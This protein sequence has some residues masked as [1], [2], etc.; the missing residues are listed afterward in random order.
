MQPRVTLAIARRNLR[1]V[2][3]DPSPIIIYLLIPLLSMVVMK[4]TQKEILVGEGFPDANGAEQVVPGFMVM[5][6][7]LWM[8]SIGRT[9]FVEHGWGTWERLRASSATTADIVM[10]KLAPGFLLMAGQIVISVGLGVVLLDLNSKGP[11]LA[12]VIVAIPLIT[13]VLAMTAAFVGLV[14][15][16]AELEAAGNLV[17]I[18]FAAIG[19]SLTPVD[20]LPQT[21]QDIAPAFPSY[22]ANEAALDV[23]LKG[24]GVSAVLA[25]AGVLLL[26]T[27][28]FGVIAAVSFSASQEKRI[29]I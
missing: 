8:I 18:V 5:F 3:G 29:E 22:W 6:I 24:K 2:L 16:Y 1:L 17:L 9:F 7:F 4:P 25:P 23:L 10:G 13:C 27:A 14:R 20:I 26:Y 12:L 19:G 21:V 28:F 15:T 11:I